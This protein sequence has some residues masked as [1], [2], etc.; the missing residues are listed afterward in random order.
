M[1][2]AE[3]SGDRFTANFSITKMV[4]FLTFNYSGFTEF[5]C[6]FL[7]FLSFFIS[8]VKSVVIHKNVKMVYPLILKFSDSNVMFQTQII[9]KDFH[10]CLIGKGDWLMDINY[11]F[12]C[13]FLFN[14]FFFWFFIL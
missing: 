8:Y 1:K 11:C 7:S 12:L 5:N 14:S 2:G 10:D 6:L 13:L 3:F 9:E 4:S